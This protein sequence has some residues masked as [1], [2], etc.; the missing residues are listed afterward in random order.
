M[1]RKNKIKV[2]I[3][4]RSI[5]DLFKSG[6]LT[7]RDTDKLDYSAV[8]S[9]YFIN[10]PQQL[11]VDKMTPI[12]TKVILAK[13]LAENQKGFS[14]VIKKHR[15]NNELDV[16]CG[17]GQEYYVRPVFY[18]S[19][20]IAPEDTTIEKTVKQREKVSDGVVKPEKIKPNTKQKIKMETT[21]TKQTTQQTE[22]TKSAKKT[23]SKKPAKVATKQTSA[24]KAPAK[25]TKPSKK[26][27]SPKASVTP[28]TP[29]KGRRGR[30]VGSKNKPKT[31]KV[32][33][34]YA[35]YGTAQTAK[36][37]RPAKQTR[38]IEYGNQNPTM[39]NIIGTV[40]SQPKD[41]ATQTLA[42]FGLKTLASGLGYDI[43]A[44]VK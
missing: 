36:R 31:T 2:V 13:H 12:G 30:P 33:Q 37:G 43:V 38:V 19:V 40:L 6:V 10:L 39:E 15:L 20:M 34:N 44:K 22:N 4:M 1:K 17:T 42:E 7:R 14:G 11:K 28:S 21:S 35:T 27:T 41:K 9:E 16:A 32:K 8:Q 26:K 18:D 3:G 5:E 23:A 24:K 25:Q 29:T